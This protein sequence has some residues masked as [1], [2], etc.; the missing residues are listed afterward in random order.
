MYYPTF[1]YCI[2]VNNKQNKQKNPKPTNQTNTTNKHLKSIYK[3]CFV[4]ALQVEYSAAVQA[5]KYILR[6]LSVPL[7]PLRLAGKIM[8]IYVSTIKVTC[9]KFVT[10]FKHLPN[11]PL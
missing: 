11:K 7:L 4:G 6:S 9:F 8:F 1:E 3:L 5:L 10:S 2:V